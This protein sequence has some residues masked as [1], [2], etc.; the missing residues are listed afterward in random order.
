VLNVI[1][2][3]EFPFGHGKRW[4][5]NWDKWVN[6]VLGGWQTNG[7][8]RFDNGQPIYMTLSGGTSLPTYGSQQP[9][10]LAPLKRNNDRSAWFTGGYFANPEVAV[11]PPPFTIGT[12]SSSI[13]NVRAPG[14]RN[15]SLSLFKEIALSRVREGMRAEFR[16]ESFNA[17]NHPQFAAP[18]AQ[19]NSGSFGV[20][21]SQANSPREVQVA[22]KLYW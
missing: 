2:V 21:S 14:T 10:L 15:A 8:W 18:D 9:N 5:G 7:V 4:G 6:G 12:A 13:P 19:V 3:Y 16:L 20:V 22:L 1:Y 11:V 17:L